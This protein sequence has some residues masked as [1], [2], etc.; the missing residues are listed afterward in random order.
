LAAARNATLTG[1]AIGQRS[2]IM[3]F[4]V[5]FFPDVRPEEIG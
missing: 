2:A 4:G 5:Q 1:T 3:Q